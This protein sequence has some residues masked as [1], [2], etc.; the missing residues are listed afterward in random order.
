MPRVKIYN[1]LYQLENVRSS[2]D[3]SVFRLMYIFVQFKKEFRA[4]TGD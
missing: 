2:R 4:S 1:L 3:E